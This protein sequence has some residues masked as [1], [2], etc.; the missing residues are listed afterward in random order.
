VMLED[1]TIK[2][3]FTANNYEVSLNTRFQLSIKNCTVK[4]EEP[5]LEEATA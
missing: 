1:A 3:L 4:T 2:N 5:V